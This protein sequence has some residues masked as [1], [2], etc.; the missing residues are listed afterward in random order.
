MDSVDAV[1]IADRAVRLG[2]LRP[3]HVDEAWLELGKRGG[4][5]VAFLRVMAPLTTYTEEKFNT[6]M[7][8]ADLTPRGTVLFATILYGASCPFG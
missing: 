1:A 4:E 2:L 7:Q 6:S 3:E 8:E 5:P